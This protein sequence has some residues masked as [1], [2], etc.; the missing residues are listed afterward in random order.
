MD[1][2]HLDGLGLCRAVRALPAGGFVPVI[3]WSNA[4]ADDSRLLEAIALGGVEFLSKQLAVSKIDPV[5]RRVLRVAAGSTR[6]GT[7]NGRR[8]THSRGA[9]LTLHHALSDKV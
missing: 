4:E 8:R 6:T 2:P 3:V 9:T 7:A 1:M 5:L